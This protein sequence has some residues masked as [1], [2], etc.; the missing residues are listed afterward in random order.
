MPKSRLEK[1]I[2]NFD[3]GD[4]DIDNLKE[5]EF[6]VSKNAKSI[7][8]VPIESSLYQELVKFAKGKKTTVEKALGQ[9]L[10]KTVL[11]AA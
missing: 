7:Y 3:A 4:T 10:K 5:V 11:K 1:L 6:S 2:E 9:I 8:M